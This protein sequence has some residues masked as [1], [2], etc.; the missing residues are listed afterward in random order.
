[1]PQ[2]VPVA[3]ALMVVSSLLIAVSATVQHYEVGQQTGP[4]E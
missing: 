2:N 3:V 4:G 1:M